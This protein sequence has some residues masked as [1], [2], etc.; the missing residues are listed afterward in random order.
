MQIH[1]RSSFGTGR[2]GLPMASHQ[3]D[4]GQ[5]PRRQLAARIFYRS[6]RCKLTASSC[7][8]EERQ[9][10][11]FAYVVCFFT[12]QDRTRFSLWCTDNETERARDREDRY[13][14]VS[15]IYPR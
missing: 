11:A 6:R 15:Y 9:R 14:D 10:Q 5:A 12:A 3:S 2:F 7:V 4:A 1:A 13:L 8:G